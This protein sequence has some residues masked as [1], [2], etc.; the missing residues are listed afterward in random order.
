MRLFLFSES[1]VSCCET[2]YQKPQNLPS[3]VLCKHRR[4]P[5]VNGSKWDVSHPTKVVPRKKVLSSLL[6]RAG[7]AF[8]SLTNNKRSL[9]LGETLWRKKELLSK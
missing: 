8:L 4:I 9:G 6:L 2:S 3:Q 1:E 5:S 7:R